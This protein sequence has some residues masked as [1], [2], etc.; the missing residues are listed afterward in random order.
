[1]A[2][3]LG[4]GLM[5]AYLVP[6]ESP[7]TILA[8]LSKDVVPGSKCSRVL[9]SVSSATISVAE[10]YD[11]PEIIPWYHSLLLSWDLDWFWYGPIV[12]VTDQSDGTGMIEAFDLM[13]WMAFRLMRDD[14]T[15]IGAPVDITTIF[16]DLITNGFAQDP[17]VAYALT[18]SATGITAEREYLASEYRLIA[19]LVAELVTTGIDYTVIT[20]GQ[21]STIV[22][23][24]VDIATGS[25]GVINASHLVTKAEV[26]RSGLDQANFTTVVGEGVVG[27]SQNGASQ[28]TYGLLDF[29]EHE[30][31]I[32]DQTSATARSATRLALR[33][34]GL[35][36]P[37][38]VKLQAKA[39]LNRDM[40]VPGAVL[41]VDL[42]G[43]FVPY[44]GDLRMNEV[45]FEVEDGR[46]VTTIAGQPVGTE[47]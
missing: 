46:W 31:D 47:S 11:G 9:N 35:V 45:T 5:G 33:T 6:R 3:P 37:N 21:T 20:E 32:V 2:G 28:T 10:C 27:Q 15:S 12:D 34:D 44:A 39:P 17:S 30:P 13:K 36:L 40:L 25:I 23:G 43:S 26:K 41:T 14:F 19:D 18:T 8:D 1:M 4:C 42:A 22:C 7:R 24:N 29:V 16:E 38:S